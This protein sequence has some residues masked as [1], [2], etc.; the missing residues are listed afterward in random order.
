[1]SV[2]RYMRAPSRS[3]SQFYGVMPSAGRPISPPPSRT[4]MALLSMPPAMAS[5][6]LMRA[7][8]YYRDVVFDRECGTSVKG[9][10]GHDTYNQYRLAAFW[11]AELPR[12]KIS[13]ILMRA[14]Q[15]F[16][17]GYEKWRAAFRERCMPSLAPPSYGGCGHCGTPK[18]PSS[19][20]GGCGTFFGK[21]K[22]EAKRACYL[23]KK[24]A[25]H[26]KCCDKDCSWFSGKGNQSN[27]CG[28][29]ARWEA[30]LLQITGGEGGAMDLS[31]GADAQLAMQYQQA[32]AVAGMR[33]MEEA[34]TK[35][36]LG[37]AAVA[38][39]GLLLVMALR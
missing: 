28:K 31:Q 24:I 4:A 29:I 1:M 22:D 30:E 10:P 26:Q 13:P 18:C 37:I 6:R 15:A 33:S 7:Y 12:A 5:D 39:G 20:Y 14:S 19:E 16:A 36:M 11:L 32:N 21:T 38:G 9:L 34:K 2:P 23:E 27:Q 8:R 3:E 35:K 25:K 17:L